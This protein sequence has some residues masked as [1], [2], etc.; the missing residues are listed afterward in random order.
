MSWG[1]KGE[2]GTAA[3]AQQ[4]ADEGPT[5]RTHEAPQNGSTH[6]SLVESW[7]QRPG[8]RQDPR[9]DDRERGP[10]GARQKE[11]AVMASARSKKDRSVKDML[12]KATIG[13]AVTTAMERHEHDEEGESPIMRS[14]LDGLFTLLKEDL[15]AV[16]LDLSQDIKEV[17]HE[18]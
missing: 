7:C 1:S 3:G 13:K 11:W 16:K 18:L 10:G 2:Y 17:R 4:R 15:Q 14:F 12:I 8:E 5:T 6:W 9:G